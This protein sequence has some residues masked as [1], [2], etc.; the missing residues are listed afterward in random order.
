MQGLRQIAIR[1]RMEEGTGEA[2]PDPTRIATLTLLAERLIQQG[3]F[4]KA[5]EAL[6]TAEKEAEG[7]AEKD[8]RLDLILRIARLDAR[9]NNWAMAGE[10]YAR[11]FDR[12][13]VEDRGAFILEAVE[14]LRRTSGP[15]GAFEFL[16][17]QEQEGVRHPR[18]RSQM[19][20]LADQSGNVKEAIRWYK[21]AL[22]ED[23]DLSEVRR[24]QL[25]DRL[26]I[27]ESGEN[28]Q[29]PERSR[30]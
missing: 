2:M 27:L 23:L 4:E 3:E 20:A 8:R 25:E 10:S 21:L 28:P 6:V 7:P 19:G 30:P 29:D 18:L 16:K 22:K 17:L 13:A 9:L 14:V 1:K 15:S 12:T 11:L 24:E 26:R 5:R